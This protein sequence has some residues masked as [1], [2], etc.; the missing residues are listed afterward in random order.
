[1]EIALDF[2]AGDQSLSAQDGYAVKSATIKKPDNLKAENIKSGVDIAGVVG[3]LES[4]GGGV[5][6]GG[7][8]MVYCDSKNA[9]ATLTN[10]S[11]AVDIPK[12]ATNIFFAS[13][14]FKVSGLHPSYGVTSNFAT[15]PEKAAFLDEEPYVDLGNGYK[16]ITAISQTYSAS[17]S[18]TNISARVN[19]VLRYTV[20]NATFQNNNLCAGS[21]CEGIFFDY[22]SIRRSCSY[23]VETIDLRGSK[24]K[25]LNGC[26]FIGELKKVWLSE[27]TT[28]LSMSCFYGCAGLE[29]IHFTS[30]TPPTVENSYTFANIATTCKIYVPA[31]SLSAYTSAANY[32]SASTYTYIEE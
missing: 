18:Y 15:I 12:D 25:R 19:F 1:M 32:P 3:T 31:G 7:L 8:E 21:N 20:P 26:E 23:F 27:M 29:E 17:A 2:S 9:T 6:A 4:G 5:S 30:T 13:D 11:F 10:C 16:R 22:N 14:L 24:V 28:E